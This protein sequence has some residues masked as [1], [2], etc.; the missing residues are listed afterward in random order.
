MFPPSATMRFLTTSPLLLPLIISAG[1]S[2]CVMNGP[3]IHM[4]QLMRVF[5]AFC[6][7]AIKWSSIPSFS[8]SR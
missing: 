2:S 5:N 6:D 3:V 7:G 1:V 8:L 4:Y